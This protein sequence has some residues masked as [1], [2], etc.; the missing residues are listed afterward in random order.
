MNDLLTFKPI[1][2]KVRS[3]N[4]LTFKYSCL[5]YYLYI[6]QDMFTGGIDTICSAL[7]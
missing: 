5:Y 2:V 1:Q 6:F 7:E 3:N 4:Y